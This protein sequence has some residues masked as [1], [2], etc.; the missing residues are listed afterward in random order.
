MTPEE[1]ALAT[2]CVVGLV[3]L[4]AFWISSRVSWPLS[5]DP[6][7]RDI[8]LA[9]YERGR[10]RHQ[11]L[12][13]GG[14]V[15]AL[16]ALGWGWA[17]KELWAWPG[18][19]GVEL[20]GLEVLTLAPFLLGQV[21]TWTF[22][23]DAERAAYKAAHRLMRDAVAGSALGA[24]P[25]AQAWL[26]AR[27]APPPSFG[28]RWS[29]V[30]FQLRQKLA[31]V[32]IPVI[33]LVL[34]KELTK[35]FP[36]SWQDVLSLASIGGL[37]VVFVCLPLLVRLALGLQPLPQG[38]LRDRLMA[39]MKRLGF[40][41]TDVLLWNTRSGMANAMVIG[42]V[43]WLR[44]VVFTDKLIEEFPEDEVEAVFGHEVGHIR[45]QHMLFYLVFL[46]GSMLALGLVMDYYVLPGLRWG[47]A[48]LL[49]AFPWLPTSLGVGP[50]GGLSMVPV[51][52]VL[53][54]YVFVV[55]GFLSRR[56]ERQADVFGCRA[57]SCGDRACEGHLEDTKLADRGGAVCPT[58]IRTF[59]RALDKVALVNG[60]DRERPGFL[61]SWQ[62]STIARRVR[63]LRRMLADGAVEP[64]FQRRLLAWKVGLM[65]L[66]AALL[67]GLGLR[68]GWPW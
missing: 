24:D 53:L 33:L 3:G 50:E 18:R 34:K 62:H 22:F 54:L 9:R 59:I 65:L 25:F 8:L 4:H 35:E 20:P 1:A 10:W 29:Y 55:F 43:P 46:M 27:Q 58:G 5:R 49:E 44:Y 64:A 45:H 2:A 12:Q 15:L 23:Y 40:R 32:S 19:E 52:V 26:E 60:I 36:D 51:V 16:T 61:Q 41:C 17:I 66:L 11:F 56:C 14:F 30:V 21:L 68:H 28:G 57:V 42:V 38:V 63:F 31:F 7:R 67:T 39:A 37:A 48:G 6:S 13:F 47:Y